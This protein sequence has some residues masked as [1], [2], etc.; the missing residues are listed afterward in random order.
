[1]ELS[2]MLLEQIAAMVLMG[3]AGFVLARLHL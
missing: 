3:A 2:L 1:M